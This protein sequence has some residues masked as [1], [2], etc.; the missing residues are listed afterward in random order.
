VSKNK[1]SLEI[2][3]INKQR[4]VMACDEKRS[5]SIT[6]IKQYNLPL[7]YLQ[8]DRKIKQIAIM[9]ASIITFSF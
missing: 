7:I 1:Q 9:L 2:N 3:R 6:V 5:N 4:E 8:Q